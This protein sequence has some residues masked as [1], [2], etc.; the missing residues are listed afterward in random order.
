MNRQKRRGIERQ[1]AT[2]DQRKSFS[3]DETRAMIN[4]AYSLGVEHALESFANKFGL[5]PKRL[6]DVKQGLELLQAL[7]F[8]Y[9]PEVQEAR[10]LNN[11]YQVKL[12]RAVRREKDKPGK[13]KILDG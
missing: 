5:G 8:E 6:E 11:M 7:D 4:E 13:G 10:K 3:P 1:A 2:F 9:S 12:N